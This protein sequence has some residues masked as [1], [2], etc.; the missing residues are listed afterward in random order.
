MNKISNQ[1]ILVFIIF[2]IGSCKEKVKDVNVA[3]KETDTLEVQK[4]LSPKTY[5]EISIK[6]GG[7]W[8]GRKYEG[9]TFV[10]VQSLNVPEEHTD[11]SYF[12]RYEGPG[13]ESNKVGYRLYLDWRNAIDIFGKTTDSLILKK[14]GQ[15][16]FDSYHELSDWGMDILKVGEG[17]GI[18]SIG[19]HINGKVL[20]FNQVDSTK[21]NVFNETGES[22]VEIDYYGWKTNKK[23]VDLKSFLSI[24][25]DSRITKHKV[26]LSDSLTGLCT[27][28]VKQGVEMVNKE[29]E[30]KQ[31]G[32]IA[33]YGKQTL[34][35]DNLGMAIFYSTQ[36]VR[37]ITDTK[38]D[39]IIEF[40]PTV[41]ECEFYFLA[42][43]EKENKGI[44]TRQ[45]FIDYLDEKLNELNTSNNF[46]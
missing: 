40:N 27:G 32:Y 29:S 20:H 16:G 5:A 24:K 8:I 39:Y 1:L 11:H 44:K 19:R 41:L 37:T 30:N 2:F 36:D 10:N 25:P 18:G 21:V 17:L 23:T 3:K 14:V 26:V 35:P 15:S 4:V 22:G 33:T 6:E 12:I 7:N 46:Y 45:E 38:F 9:G 42:A 13:W 31:W 43:W 34:V 28:I